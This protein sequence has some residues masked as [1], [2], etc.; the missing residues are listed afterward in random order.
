[1]LIQ[2]QMVGNEMVPGLSGGERK[3]TTISEAMV[4]RGAIDC[5]DCSTR[6]L[7][8]ASALDYAKS[9]RVITQTLHKTTLATFYQAS[10]SIYQQFDRVLVLDKGRCIFFGPAKEAKQ[11]FLDLG[12]DCEHRKSTP[13]FLTGLTNPQER[14]IRAGAENVPTNSVDLEAAYKRSP[15]YAR[16]MQEL[17][18]Y[19]AQIAADKPHEDFKKEFQMQKAKRARPRS[20]Y[21]ASLWEQLYALVA[22]QA[23]MFWGDK[24]GIFSRYF[25]VIVQ[26]LVFGSVFYKMP[27][28][29]TGGFSRGGALFSSLLFN[30]FLSQGELF[31]TFYGRRIIQKQK[32]YAMYHPFAFHLAQVRFYSNYTSISLLLTFCAGCY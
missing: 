20:I 31:G 13:D 11:Y 28:N 17:K 4:S 6:G 1:M 10:E 7:D 3:R 25:S 12:F 14:K 5:W 8:A 19:E 26:G 24:F 2:S 32:S 30:A 27:L 9:L 15:N 29:A 23:G 21:S 16:A 18:E 22:R